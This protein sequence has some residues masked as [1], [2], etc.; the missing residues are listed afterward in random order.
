MKQIA[1]VENTSEIGAGTRGASLGIDAL[2]LASLKE[3]NA[4]F[5]QFKTYRVAHKNA[6]LFEENRT[7]HA[8]RIEGILEVYENIKHAVQSCLVQEDFPI[9]LAADH[10]SAG[11]TIAGIK[12]HY[13]S[14]RL[15]VIWIDAHGD[16]HSP[17]T[18]PSGNVHGMPLA[19]SIAEDNIESAVNQLDAGTAKAW[20][21]LKNV[22][23]VSPKIHPED[24][25]FFGV[26][27]T[28][29][30]EEHLIEKYNIKNYTVDECRTKGIKQC[31]NE[32]LNRLAD[33]DILY[34]SFDVDSMDPDIV[35]Y[36]TGTPVPHGFD[37][38]EA[39]I[40][41]ETLAQDKRLVCFEMVEINPLLDKEN[42][43]AETAFKI[44]EYA[45]QGI[46]NNL[47]A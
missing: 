39:Q 21:S 25:V 40:I 24:I 17:Y 29:A 15:G 32:A 45:V 5:R 1:F 23:G 9:I 16:L 4:F 3:N 26:R 27:D 22:G 43:M 20:D 7:P 10:A 11:G 36:G 8:I 47:K 41:I 31:A 37:P 35:S 12:Q 13:P 28:E 44:L 33:C 34:I 2:K 46:Q 30:P 18:T 6:M 19:I 42:K 14:K 38:K